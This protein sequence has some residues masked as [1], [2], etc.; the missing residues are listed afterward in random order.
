MLSD[1]KVHVRPVG[2]GADKYIMKMKELAVAAKK[3]VADRKK[4][5]EAGAPEAGAP[6][7]NE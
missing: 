5:E 6:E 1:D 3:R 7:A 4:K 2:P